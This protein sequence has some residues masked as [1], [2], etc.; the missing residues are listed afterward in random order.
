MKPVICFDQVS[1]YYGKMASLKDINLTIQAGEVLAL[2]GHNG[3]GKTTAMKLILGLIAPT[4]GSIRVFDAAPH[5]VAADRLRRQV[6]FLPE[7]VHFY[8]QLS[9][10][11][12]LDYLARL[13]GINRQQV[14]SLIEQVGLGSAAN[15][16][17]K[18]YSKGMRQRLGLAQALLGKPKLM[19]LDEA[20]T[21][22]DPAATRDFY[23]TINNLRQQGCT[24]LLSSH[25]LSGIEPYLDRALI[26][27]Q[28]HCLALGNLD[29]LRQQTNLPLT[30]RVTG[31]S[32]V[33]QLIATGPPTESCS[34]EANVWNLAINP[35]DKMALL[36]HLSNSS[37]VTN[38]ELL[39]PGLEQIYH[40]YSANPLTTEVS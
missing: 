14:S 18:T 40:H 10:L 2:L 38:I 16:R 11:E 17:V 4:R 29:Q 25:I 9:G 20:T 33:S 39:P 28:G 30:V 23:S 21:G 31:S 13:K 1:K 8:D 3:A 37:E 19:L 32:H 5:G 7:N 26:L 36:R 15:R 6:G 24:V 34:Q 12:V 27:G 22:L 35:A